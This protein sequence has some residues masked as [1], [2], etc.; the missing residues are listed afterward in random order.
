MVPLYVFRTNI[1]HFPASQ[2]QFGQ[3]TNFQPIDSKTDRWAPFLSAEVAG[4]GEY[5]LTRIGSHMSGHLKSLKIKLLKISSPSCHLA[6]YLSH[7]TTAAYLSHP[8]TAARLLR[9]PAPQDVAAGQGPQP[10]AC[11]AR[12]RPPATALARVRRQPPST[13]TVDPPLPCSGDARL[14]P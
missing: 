9:R 2:L 7:P 13:L 3:I 5:W 12:A 11:L 10:P 1:Y 8:T 6:A 4:T 14:R